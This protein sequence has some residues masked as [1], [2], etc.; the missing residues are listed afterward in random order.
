MPT[1]TL[2]MLLAALALTAVSAAPALAGTPGHVRHAAAVAH[3]HGA[4]P[5]IFRGTLLA[6]GT[7]G[8]TSLQMQVVG[9][10]RPALRA[11]LGGSNP[12]TFTVGNATRYIVWSGT[13]PAAGDITALHAGDLV[14]VVIWA[15]RDTALSALAALP[16]DRVGDI[17][18]FTRPDGR[19]YL[20][21]GTVTSTD[22]T[23]HTMTITV[24]WGNRPALRSLLGAPATET[25][26]YD[27][28]TTFVSW[29]HGVPTV[30][31][32]PT[33]FAGVVWLRIFAPPHT[34]LSTLLTTP[35]TIVG[36]HVKAP[37]T[38]SPVS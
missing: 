20:Y 34:P 26:S 14:R 16:A 5:Y 4:I 36:Q 23:A 33:G 32:D 2:R 15:P 38:A 31:H 3:R 17:A 10:D 1:R 11:M 28:S 27:S 25:F 6:D 19:Q 24:G 7:A 29:S 21:G 30:S 18:A 35:T 13:S 12:V 9:G 8:A 22:T 37:A